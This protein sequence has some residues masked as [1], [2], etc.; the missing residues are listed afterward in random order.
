MT[1]HASRRSAL[2]ALLLSGGLA[3][4]SPTALDAIHFS[5]DIHIQVPT[6]AAS[7]AVVNDDGLS[8]LDL[9]TGFSID[10]NWLGRL[11]RSDLDGFHFGDEA[12]GT[13]R[14]FSLTTTSEIAGTV[15]RPGDVFTEAGAKVFDAVAV[16]L[17]RNINVDALSRDPGSCDLV[18]SIDGLAELGGTVFGPR[19]L[20][21]WNSTDGFSLFQT[22]GGRYNVDA[23]H[24]LS[25]DR[26]LLSFDI[27]QQ[28]GGQ[29]VRD[30]DVIEVDFSG[31]MPSFQLSYSPRALDPSIAR[32][33]LD[34]LWAQPSPPV[35]EFQWTLSEDSV[36]ENGGSI[37]VQI[38]RVNGSAG[39]VSVSVET[40][41]NT[42]IAGVDYTAF[43]GTADF[44][45]AELARTVT[46]PITDNATLE[47][48]RQFFVDL[49][50]VSNGALGTP[51]RITV[52]IRDDEDDLL[53]DDRFEN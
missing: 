48:N 8:Q 4:Q 41:D 24:V 17:P 30:D 50:A 20:I 3:A 40:A 2:A 13:D 18:L 23:L 38:E 31:A 6:G 9:A 37:V 34:A 43:V 44:V 5:T 26:V 27:D 45:D 1:R 22:L 15:M 42:A 49:T 12:C 36:F 7:S 35:G 14:L 53:F 16:G 10:I 19:D 29:L 28:L 52:L 33:D 46:I 39:A 47:G 51:T 25:A 21:Q 32:A 11:D